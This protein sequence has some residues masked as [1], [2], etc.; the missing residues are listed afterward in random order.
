MKSQANVT[1]SELVLFHHET[2]FHCLSG[3]KLE[4]ELGMSYTVGGPVD[5]EGA[6]KKTCE[7]KTFSIRSICMSLG[8]F[9]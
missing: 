6:R 2:R 9:V 8:M 3:T 1:R 5:R 4:D 7:D